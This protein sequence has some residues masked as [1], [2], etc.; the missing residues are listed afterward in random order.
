MWLIPVGLNHR[1][2]IIKY[3]IMSS[4]FLL[5]S[6]CFYVWIII[7]KGLKTIVSS[8]FHSF[9]LVSMIILYSFYFFKEK[10]ERFQ[11]E[12]FKYMFADVRT[13]I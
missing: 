10:T 8:P 5:N 11:K 2:N 12:Y 4:H 1:T 7:I 9:D 13:N 6:I 3:I